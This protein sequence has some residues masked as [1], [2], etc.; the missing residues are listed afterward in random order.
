MHIGN[1]CS[2]CLGF[3]SG[4]KLIHSAKATHKFCGT[5]TTATCE[6]V[7]EGHLLPNEKWVDLKAYLYWLCAH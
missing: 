1:K 2:C 5:L 4:Q 7:N 6:F 3:P